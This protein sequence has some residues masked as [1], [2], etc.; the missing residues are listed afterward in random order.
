MKKVMKARWVY[1]TKCRKC[2]HLEDW[3]LGP[4][5]TFTANNVAVF[6]SNKIAH[7]MIDECPE[8]KFIAVHDV[9]GVRRSD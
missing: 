3:V 5:D 7:P 9:L 8:C 2:G 6:L 4:V 1:Q